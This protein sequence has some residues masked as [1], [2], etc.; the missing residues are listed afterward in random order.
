M[1]HT[2]VIMPQMGESVAEG[3]VAKWLKSIGEKVDRDENIL[4]ISTDKIDVEVPSPQSGFLRAILVEE[5]QTV[6]VG[7]PIAVIA[8]SA[9]EE[10]DGVE[11]A[12]APAK[13]PEPEKV[14]EVKDVPAPSPAPKPVTATKVVDE[15]DKRKFYTPVVLRMAAEHN[16]NLEEVTGTGLG[17]R[18]T[19]KDVQNFLKQTKEGPKPAA[20][21]APAPAF[22]FTPGSDVEIIE[23]SNVRKKTAEH[24]VMSKST[25]A[26]VHSMQEVDMTSIAKHREAIKEDFKKKNGYPLS[27]MAIVTKEVCE[28]IKEFPIINSSV[29]GDRIVVKKNIN[30]GMAVA[31][32]DDTL[33]V[34]VIK[35]ADK[36][37][38]SG[39]AAAIWD[40]AQ[41]ARSK[42]LTIDDIQG[43]TFT[44]TNHGV[45]GSVF[46]SP[47]INQ[48]QVAILGTGAMTKRPVVKEGPEGDSIA[49]RTMMF[50]SLGYD[51]RII[52][53]GYGGKFCRSIAERLES[54]SPD[55]M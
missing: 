13:Q 9:D 55:R 16:I 48:P 29:D 19:K 23:M 7:T 3:T 28:A 54:W 1:A 51:H 50:L 44:I 10:I 20:A 41:R 47:I 22:T 25:S 8:D 27:Y 49:I 43:G 24:M 53:G 21:P 4:E 34:P 46:G 26:H 31:L 11:A 40:L 30:I 36:L 52:D 33:I 15:G 18:V 2:K 32:P 45:F 39:I 42:K 37:N 12:P 14:E 6:E 17:G 5:G 38:T 35:N